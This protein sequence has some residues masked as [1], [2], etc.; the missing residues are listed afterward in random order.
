[1]KKIVV[2]KRVKIPQ[3]LKGRVEER[4]RPIRI[5]SRAKNIVADKKDIF[6]GEGRP[7][8]FRRT[9]TPPGFLQKVEESLKEKTEQSLREF[10]ISR[11]KAAVLARQKVLD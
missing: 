10:Q 4:I 8:K 11:I 2:T 7:R 1:M 5:R 9:K 6:S 3:R